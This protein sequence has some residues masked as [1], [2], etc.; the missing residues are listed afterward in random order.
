[1]RIDA[2]AA[3]LRARNATS[4]L[5]DRDEVW[6]AKRAALEIIYRQPL[7]AARRAAFE[8]FRVRE[9][10]PLDDWAAWCALAEIHG[11]DWRGW[12]EPLRDAALGRGG[13]RAGPAAGRPSSTPGCSGWPTS[14]WPRRRRRRAA[15]GMRIGDHPATSRSA[16]TRAAPTPGPAGRAGP[17]VSVGAP[18]DEFNQRGQDWA[19]RPGIPQRLAAAGYAPLA[20][21]I[22][23]APAARRRPA[24]RSRDGAV[25]AVVGARR[26][27]R[28]TRAPTCGTTTEAMVGVLAGEAARAG[29]AGHRRGP[30]HGEPWVR[31]YLAARGV[32][33][34]SMLWFERDPDGT[35]LPPGQWRR[36]C[37]ATVGTHDVPPVAA[38]VTG[39]QVELRARLGLLPA[40][41]EAERATRRRVAAG[42]AGR[43]GPARGCRRWRPARPGGVHRGA[44]RATWPAPRPR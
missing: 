26:D 10:Q 24:G 33:G 21:L 42:L 28:P 2:L 18:P 19:S 7:T 41:P 29:G 38:F 15:A 44:L 5:I 39:E 36:D 40:R 16:R 17:G 31:D 9:G 30:R 3:P 11:P 1:M 27:D 34:T 37:L 43:P 8:R 32:L 13:G 25:P 20:G 4:E 23:R 35:P 6:R 12:P 22:A 14:S